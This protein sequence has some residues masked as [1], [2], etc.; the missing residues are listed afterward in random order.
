MTTGSTG[1]PEVN[2]RLTAAPGPPARPR[3]GRPTRDNSEQLRDRLLDVATELLLTQGY[4]ATSIEAIAE[5]ARVSKRTF[6]HRF[7]GK[8]AL[9]AAVVARL[10][11]S[12]RPPAHVALVEGQGLD[13]ILLH[14]AQ[15]ILKAAL[16]PRALALHRLIVAESERFPELAAAVAQAGGRRGAATLIGELLAQH[17]TDARL[18][19]DQYAFAA[20][21]F[22]QMIVSLPQMRAMGIG[23]PMSPEELDAWARQSV[24]LFLGGFARVAG[25]DGLAPLPRKGSRRG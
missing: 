19:A 2:S 18:G 9:M 4:G 13:Q 6:Y 16:M 3:G 24:A 21:Q 8:P 10:I 11:D 14:L 12:L 1:T 23:T 7:A 25:S 20:N 17:R 5:R 15:L 22:L